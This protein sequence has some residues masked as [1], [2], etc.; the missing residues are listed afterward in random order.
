MK[1]LKLVAVLRSLLWTPKAHPRTNRLKAFAITCASQR[2]TFHSADLGLECAGEY[3]EFV[4]LSLKSI[5]GR[6]NI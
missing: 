3:V 4:R 1:G 2:A 6:L 5:R